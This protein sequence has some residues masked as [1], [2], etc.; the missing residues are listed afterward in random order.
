MANEFHI[1]KNELTQIVDGMIAIKRRDG[2]ENKTLVRKQEIHPQKDRE[3]RKSIDKGILN[4]EKIVLTAVS[5]YPGILESV[6]KYIRIDD[7]VNDVSSEV[8]KMLRDGILSNNLNIPKIFDAFVEKNIN[9]SIVLN[10]DELNQLSEEDTKKALADAIK[11]ILQKK[12][13]IEIN[14]PENLAKIAELT[15]RKME[16]KNF[17]LILTDKY[18]GRMS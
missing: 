12:N 18:Y 17:Q 3:E 13:E 5:S 15:N 16:L 7:L 6:E 9:I 8:G 4:A 14:K 1:D 2:G 10:S 11:K